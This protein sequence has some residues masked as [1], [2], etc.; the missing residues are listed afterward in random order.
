[1]FEGLGK[2]AAYGGKNMKNNKIRIYQCFLSLRIFFI[3]A[4]TCL[5]IDI[6]MNIKNILVD[7]KI[8]ELFLY[9]I[10]VVVAPILLFY[11]SIYLDK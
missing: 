9:L 1:M 10:I 3:F 2:V 8:W 5:F 7:A 11:S 4:A 6:I